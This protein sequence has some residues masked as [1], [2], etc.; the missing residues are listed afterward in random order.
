MFDY[1]PNKYISQEDIDFIKKKFLN[2]NYNTHYEGCW[3]DHHACMIAKLMDAIT[4]LK[5]DYDTATAYDYRSYAPQV[6]QLSEDRT[7]NSP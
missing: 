6:W 4:N 2:V 7:Q 1:S 3:K 5:A